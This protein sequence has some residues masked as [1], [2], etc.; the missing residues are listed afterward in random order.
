MSDPAYEYLKSNM[1][2]YAKKS[3]AKDGKFKALINDT[4]REFQKIALMQGFYPAK[5]SEETTINWKE[6]FKK[7]SPRQTI[8]STSICQKASETLLQ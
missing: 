3:L 8:T 4:D 1:L 7:E 2:T 5:E 6:V